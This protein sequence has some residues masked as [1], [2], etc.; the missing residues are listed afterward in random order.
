LVQDLTQSSPN[1]IEFQ[2]KVVD[3]CKCIGDLFFTLSQNNSHSVKLLLMKC[4]VQLS[5]SQARLEEIAIIENLKVLF[6][7]LM[8]NVEN[9]ALY[10]SCLELWWTLFDN[11]SREPILLFYSDAERIAQIMNQ[12]ETIGRDCMRQ[13]DKQKRNSMLQFLSK[14]LKLGD[15]ASIFTEIG[16]HDTVFDS[17]VE[18]ELGETYNS[19][20]FVRAFG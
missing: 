8:E 5:R 7:V 4:L 12:L 9:D 11:G 3:A 2:L 10:F 18:N 16:V 20:T 14:V 1:E 15:N 17:L 13:K 19:N 6:K